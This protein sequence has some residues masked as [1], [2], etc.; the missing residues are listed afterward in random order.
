MILSRDEQKF[1]LDSENNLDIFKNKFL[2]ET[3]MSLGHY[4][5]F[6]KLDL[7]FNLV[8]IVLSKHSEV[9]IQ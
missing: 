9:N 2:E 3:T 5:P 8:K 1:G 6:L 4:V 7:N